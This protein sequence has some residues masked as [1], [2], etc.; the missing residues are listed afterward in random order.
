MELERGRRGGAV[1]LEQQRVH[2]A[3]RLDVEA[4][5]IRIGGIDARHLGVVVVESWGGDADDARAGDGERSLP[6]PERPRVVRCGGKNTSEEDW[7]PTRT[8]AREASGA[9][10]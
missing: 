1:E 7:K 10:R 3:A 4:H 5:P 6:G 9:S 2:A 8:N